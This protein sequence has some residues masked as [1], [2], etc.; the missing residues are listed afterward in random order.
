MHP[1]LIAHANFIGILAIYLFENCDGIDSVRANKFQ[2]L[3]ISSDE[4]VCPKEVPSQVFNKVRSRIECAVLCRET[5]G[6]VGLN[7]KTPNTCE[8]YLYPQN[9]FIEIG[10]G[11]TYLNSGK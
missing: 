5:P 1:T 11:C 7:W 10:T 6:C 8:M 2:V 3:Q 9:T 4:N